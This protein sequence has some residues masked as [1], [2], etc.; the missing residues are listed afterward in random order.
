MADSEGGHSLELLLGDPPLGLVC[1]ICRL[2]AREPYQTGCCGKLFCKT[3]LTRWLQQRM[4]CPHCQQELLAG[5][6]KDVRAAQEIGDLAVYCLHKSDGC[7]W[8]GELRQVKGHLKECVHDTKQTACARENIHGL[9]PTEEKVERE[10]SHSLD[11]VKCEQCGENVQSSQLRSHLRES[12]LQRHY[13]CPR[14]QAEGAYQ[15]MTTDHVQ[16]CPGLKL[17]CPNQGCSELI[18]INKIEEHL[19]QC[20]GATS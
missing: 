1:L 4:S 6:F 9:Q 18:R 15:D 8:T 3:C 10:E 2:V 19:R 17:P 12:C 14:C 7:D 5:C 13:Q 11:L 20:T 16:R